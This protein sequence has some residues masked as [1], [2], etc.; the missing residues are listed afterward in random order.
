MKPSP[1]R[2]VALFISI[3]MIIVSFAAANTGGYGMTPV[4]TGASSDLN[5]D[6]APVS[7]WDLTV[8]EILIAVCLSFFPVFVYPVEIFFLLKMLAV[9]GYRKVEQNAV[10]YNRNRQKIQD[11]VTANPGINFSALERLTGI[12]EG[13][14][15]YHLIILG[16]KRK[17]ISFGTGRSV[18]YFENNGRYSELEKKVLPHLQNPTTR[19]ILGILASFP[20]VSRKDI[21]GMVGIAGPSVSWHTKRLSRDGIISTS[22]NGRGVRYTLCAA[23]ADIFRKYFGRGT[24]MAASGDE[25]GK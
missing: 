24:G 13:T 1:A 5:Q 14:L 9:L 3:F 19:R 10:R 22:K 8:R 12:K 20:E 11:T 6:P 18:R 21:A 7:F 17:I 16:A 4:P 2:A 23:G 15:K 25:A